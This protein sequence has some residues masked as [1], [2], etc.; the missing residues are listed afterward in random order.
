MEV[1]CVYGDGTDITVTNSAF[2]NNTVGEYGGGLYIEGD[3]TDITV[4][5]S[6]FTNNTVG[7]YGGGLYIDGDGTDITVTNSAFTS[8]T[9]GGHGGGLYID[10]N[11][12]KYTYIITSIFADNNGS[13][14]LAYSHVT[15]IY[16]LKDIVL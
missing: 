16:L 1:D 7:R 11:T 8:N 6:A 2:T 15:V 12:N 5:N 13:G 4:T 14:I 3:G 10:S 9:I